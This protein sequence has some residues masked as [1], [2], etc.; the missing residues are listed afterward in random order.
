MAHWAF[1]I[2]DKLI[3]KK[4]DKE[5]Y[6]CACGI[7]PSGSVHIGNFRDVAT[8]LFVARALSLRG[9]KVR[10]LLS[11][12]DFDRL[13]KVPSNISS[14]T[15]NFEQNIGKPY[16]FIADPF[17]TAKS[18]GTHFEEEF[19]KSLKE[20]DITVD[21]R[22]QTEYYTS[23]KYTEQIKHALER[24]KEIY[25]IIMSYKTQDANDEERE[26]YYP[27]SVY[28]KNCQKDN[29]KVV[30]YDE[31]SGTLTY[32]CEDCKAEHKVNINDY[33]F[34]KLV[35][36]VDWPMRWRYEGVDFE[37]GGIDHASANGSYDVA[38]DISRK[39][40]GYEA[41]MFQGYGWLGIRGLGNMHSSTGNN[42]TPA[43][44]L[45]VY[46]PDIIKWLFAKYRPEDAFDF[47]F[48]DVVIRHYSEYDKLL[49]RARSGEVTDSEKEL[50]ELLFGANLPEDK[51][52]FGNIAG[53]APVV[54]FNIELLTK[55]LQKAGIEFKQNSTDRVGKVKNWIEEYNPNKKYVLLD[56]K[57]QE[58]FESLSDEEKTIIKTLHNYI[59][60]N[61]FTEKEIQL[62]IYSVI[63]DESLSKKE[64]VSRQQQNFKNIYNLLFGRDDGPRLYLFLSAVEKAKYLDLLNF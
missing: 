26:N 64:N 20:L 21:I 61:N 43:K 10:L 39:I 13:R 63:N 9:K 4:G 25:D 49:Y 38:K 8:S 47:A 23:G 40:F 34:V 18:Y 58:Y 41:P 46:E 32:Y 50:L 35:W 12:D 36:K 5:E 28:C 27:V 24:R 56:G 3:A 53:V 17:G 33:H 14:F 29:T 48:D 37:P 2:A 59:E 44:V 6:V 51:I 55:A 31:E 62:Y 15:Q 52:S 30:S 42:I 19:E 7:S 54:D 60:N 11:W 45:E 16:T 1:E 57:N 22:R